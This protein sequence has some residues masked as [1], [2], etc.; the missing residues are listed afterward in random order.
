M[1]T[2]MAVFATGTVHAAPLDSHRLYLAAR[3]EIPWQS[4]S[5]EEQRALRQHRDNWDKYSGERQKDM[6][7]GARRYMNLPA[8]KQHQ[9]EQQRRQF[10]QLSPEERKRLREEYKRQKR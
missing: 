1:L 10:Q 7:H 6:R 9:L 3:G 5:P 4:L 8:K 2:T